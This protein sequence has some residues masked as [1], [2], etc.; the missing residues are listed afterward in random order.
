MC[1]RLRGSVR[2]QPA[3]LLRVLPSKSAPRSLSGLCNI[4]KA[5]PAKAAAAPLRDEINS[6]ARVSSL[7][8]RVIA[9]GRLRPAATAHH[10]L[11]RHGRGQPIVRRLGLGWLTL[12]SAGQ[13]F[14]GTRARVW[15]GPR[16]MPGAVVS[17][18]NEDSACW[19][20]P[21]SFLSAS[22]AG[23]SADRTTA[24]TKRTNPT[25]T[26]HREAARVLEPR[27]APAA[28]VT[29]HVLRAGHRDAVPLV[30]QLAATAVADTAG[31]AAER[32]RRHPRRG[33]LCG[34]WRCLGRG[35]GAGRSGTACRRAGRQPARQPGPASRP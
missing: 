12:R 13:R 28:A 31:L 9:E 5:T 22:T 21:V 14:G 17:S 26:P 2:S 20:R 23:R 3:R 4:F 29:E 8:L 32:R 33:A 6:G 25:T 27:G 1:S 19:A 24:G 15:M 18:P 7:T 30:R 16:H 35:V 34:R 10:R 11:P